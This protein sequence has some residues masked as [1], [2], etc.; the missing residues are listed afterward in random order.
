M[1]DISK[2]N[3]FLVIGSG[4]MGSGI[5]GHIANAGFTVHLLDIV[6]ANASDR[7]ILAKQ[8]IEKMNT[9][10]PENIKP[11]NLED[12]LEL[13]K[14]ADWIIEAII[15]KL[16]I[17]Q[18]LYKIL[19]QHCSEHCIISSNTSTIPLKSLVE[20]RTSLFKRNF[21]ITH[22]F[23]PARYMQLL[24]LVISE[25]TDPKIA[26][27]VSEFIDIFL[28][29]T[30]VNS[31]DTPG[32][33]ANRIG[34]YWLQVALSIA[35]EMNIAIEEVDSLISK[36][37]GI[38]STAIFGLYD[39]IGIDVMKLISF[40][41]AQS[42]DKADEFIQIANS[43]DILETLLKKGLLGRKV[44]GGFYRINKDQ[45]GKKTKQVL[46]LKTLNYR[47]FKELG[48][49]YSS[50][51]IKDLF[52]NN[53]YVNKVL[54]KTLS[55]A[56]SLIPEVTSDL[57]AIDQAMKLGYNWKYGPFELIDIIGSD[58]FKETLVKQNIS[59]PKVL[60]ELKERK[61]YENS[62]YFKAGNY[63]PIARPEGIIYLKDFNKI[64]CQNHS[65]VIFDLKQDVALLKINTNVPI[66]SVEIFKL[67]QEF[68]AT[69]INQYKA[70]IIRG[71]EN[72]FSV[73]ADLKYIL[74][75]INNLDL[76]EEYLSLGQK[77][78]Q[79]LKYSRI[80]IISA[81]RG[82]SLGGGC[83][84]LLHSSMIVSHF[85]VAAGL[86]ETN[87]GLVPSWGGCKELIQRANTESE[88]V[89]A[90]K[91]IMSAKITSS[92]KELSQIL[93]YQNIQI[94]MN[95]N[96]VLSQAR[97]AAL[98]FKFF[99]DT[100]NTN[101]FNIDWDYVIHSM[102]LKEYDLVIAN[103]L[104]LLFSIYDSTEE[105]LF[106]KERS[107]F[108]ELLKDKRTKDRIEYILKFKKKLEN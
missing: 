48:H 85:E 40:S 107:T 102:N 37:I 25:Y 92:A 17:K 26:I 21:L 65:C 55:Y 10:R 24:E 91:N 93:N 81:L 103:K 69:Q 96:R 56:A 106:A 4:V 42:L 73:G 70:L 44:N 23:N 105:N 58:L 59:V 68:F 67:I 89:F 41:L 14:E 3:N 28:G 7:N 98:N 11:G 35:L 36:P 50:V 79:L 63:V 15:E 77:T 39:L 82:M 90:F 6:P 47:D 84:L 46:D 52:N 29:K 86:V 54:T 30:I 32:F 2:I 49:S 19:E 87:V 38:P 66:L 104:K 97:L 71:G 51:S 95:V 99:S 1:E 57:T 88:L 34:C 60:L 13:I 61:F 16:P 101:K 27:K 64:I 80:P 94:S 18:S 8:A 72:N 53:L 5:A 43:N 108:L 76:I 62:T 9:V 12:D 78:M 74:D 100:R 31:N 20:G 45:N 83:E 22:F 33:I 75:N